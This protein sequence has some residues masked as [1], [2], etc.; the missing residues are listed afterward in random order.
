MEERINFG[1]VISSISK[2]DEQ[3]G[4]KGNELE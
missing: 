1:G 3:K 4:I 2:D